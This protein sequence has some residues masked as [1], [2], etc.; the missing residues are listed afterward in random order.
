[1]IDYETY[2]KIQRDASSG[3][4]HRTCSPFQAAAHWVN[5]TQSQ[6]LFVLPHRSGARFMPICA[7]SFI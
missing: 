5:Q 7:T 1:M 4:N 3:A 2:A 6:G